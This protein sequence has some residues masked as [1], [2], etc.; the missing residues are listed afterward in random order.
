M[1][2]VRTSCRCIHSRRHGWINQLWAINR[3]TA[4]ISCYESPHHDYCHFCRAPNFMV[5]AK[6][7]A[8]LPEARTAVRATKLYYNPRS[9]RVYSWWLIYWKIIIIIHIVCIVSVVV[10]CGFVCGYAD[11]ITCLHT[12]HPHANTEH[13]CHS[14]TPFVSS[15]LTLHFNLPDA[16]EPECL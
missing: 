9:Y 14:W 12:A 2:E 8:C 5:I 13:S 3:F 7:F 15:Y 11:N 4:S 1:R 6:A 10:L 16:V